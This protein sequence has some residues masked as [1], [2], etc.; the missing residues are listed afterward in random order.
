MPRVSLNGVDLY[1]EVTGEGFPVIFSHEYAGN[2]RSWDPQVKFF[3]RLYQCVT[4]CHRGFP[5]SSVPNDLD[6]YSQDLLVEDLHGLVQHLGFDQAHFV[7]FSM[8][9]NV[10]LS[11]VIRYPELC[12][13]AVLVGC[14]AGSVGR[15]RFE[16]DV[17][18]VVELLESRGIDAFAEAYA[19]G[20]TRQ[21]FKRKDPKGWAEFRD[22]LAKHSPIGQSLTIQGVQHRRP[23]VFSLEDQMKTIKV[24]TLVLLGDEDE[25]AM[26]SS[27]FMKRK[28]ASSGLAVVPQSGHT[29]NLEEPELFNQLVMDFLRMAETGRWATRGTVT[30]SLMPTDQAG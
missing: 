14:G 19:N 27:V 9:A 18:E 17:K 28:I 23:T 15:E 24:P 13:S 11:F 26:D 25:P 21:P 4:Y 8:G 5:P 7:G 10:L 29:V 3:D 22:E 20:P 30:T 12:R 6:A 16:Q 2:Y 1:Y